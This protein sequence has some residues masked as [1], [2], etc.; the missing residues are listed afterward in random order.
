MTDY[1]WLP[2]SEITKHEP[3]M[4]R[5]GVSKVARARGGFM[6]YYKQARG[7]PDF[8][9]AYWKMRRVAFIKRFTELWKKYRTERVK[10]ALIAWAYMPKGEVRGKL[11]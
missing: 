11:R 1:P 2:L 10:L 7:N 8:M 6:W 4:K 5:L 3:E 9:S